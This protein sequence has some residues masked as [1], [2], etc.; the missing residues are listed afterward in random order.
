MK[1]MKF[2]HLLLVFTVI[3]FSLSCKKEA[4]KHSSAQLYSVKTVCGDCTWILQNG[5]KPLVNKTKGN[6]NEN[7]EFHAQ[8]GDTILF[9]GYN[10]SASVNMDGYLYKTG[11]ELKH[12]T[13]HC[14]GNPTFFMEHIVE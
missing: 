11:V 12:G 8:K 9:F 10:Y 5:S 1:D 2:T 3:A 7:F 6:Y 14:G 13:T 4:N